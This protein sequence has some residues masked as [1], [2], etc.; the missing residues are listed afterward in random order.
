MI[1]RLTR[2]AGALLATALASSLLAGT[3]DRAYLLTLDGESHTAFLKSA[4]STAAIAAYLVDT[5]RPAV[6]VCADE[7][8]PQPV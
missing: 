2:V 6:R 5:R 8:Q 4:C 3:L 1:S 7:P